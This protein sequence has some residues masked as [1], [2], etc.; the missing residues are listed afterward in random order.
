MSR[1]DAYISVSC[2][3]EGCHESVELH[4]TALAGGSWDERSVESQLAHEGWSKRDNGDDWCRS[5]SEEV[6]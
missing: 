5:C 1:S 2:D 3:H 4:I 6:D